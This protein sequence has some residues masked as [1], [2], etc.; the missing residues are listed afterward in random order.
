MVGRRAAG[1]FALIS[2]N[3]TEIPKRIAVLEHPVVVI[4]PPALR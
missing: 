2:A 4:V 1:M 3:S